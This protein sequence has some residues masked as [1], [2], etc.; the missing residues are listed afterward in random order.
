MRI[1][2]G[3][4]L[5]ASQP[6]RFVPGQAA[7]YPNR[8]VSAVNALT[9]CPTE[10][11]TRNGTEQGVSRYRGGDM[12][13]AEFAHGAVPPPLLLADYRAAGALA[14]VP[15]GAP[16]LNPAPPPWGSGKWIAVHQLVL[17]NPCGGR[18]PALS[19]P[20][21]NT[22]SLAAYPRGFSLEAATRGTMA[23]RAIEFLVDGAV[24]RVQ[25]QPRWAMLGN[26][27][28]VWTPWRGYTMGRIHTIRARPRA[29]GVDRRYGRSVQLRV[30]A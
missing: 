17:V 11:C 30:V 13:P 9:K 16:P 24:V 28:G 14:P 3:A 5:L 1:S 20:G 10:P 12:L 29:A 22:V 15:P 19:S 21:V 26:A 6:R 7:R 23:T 4:N 8:C 18:G 25:W 2:G 27:G